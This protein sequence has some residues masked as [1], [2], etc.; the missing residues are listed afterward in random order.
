MTTLIT[1]GT[2]RSGLSLAKLLQGANRPVII[3]S[4]SGEAP[5]PFKAVK[6]DWFDSKTYENALSDSSIDR[7]YIVGPPGSA[8]SSVL[9]SFIDLAVSKGVKRFVLLSA[10]VFEPQTNSAIPASVVHQYLL[11]K[12]VDYVVLRPTWFIQNFGAS[13]LVSI[14]ENN[15]VFSAAQ[16][17][18]LPWVSTED[19]GQAAFEALTAEP[20]PNKD[21]FVV[22]PELHSYADAAKIA[23]SVLGRTINYKRFT[24]EEQTA[25]YTQLGVSP[26]YAKLLAEMDRGIEEG[27]EEALFN[28]PKTAAEG[29][30][31]I[32]PDGAIIPAGVI[33]QYLLEIGVNY[34]VLRPAR[35]IGKPTGYVIML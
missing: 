25:F 35:F 14:K 33:H 24:V 10:T 8:D 4:R 30:K 28:D 12:G 21:I 18:R 27:H 1:G 20:S 13:F 26:E 15:E 3:A 7:V 19:I 9:I 11:D 23:S 22:G 32:G 17:G 5:K 2:G 6:F 29:R 31:F 34:T 16:D